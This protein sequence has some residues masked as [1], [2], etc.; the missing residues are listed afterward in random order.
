MPLSSVGCSFLPIVSKY[1]LQFTLSSCFH[2]VTERKRKEGF[3]PLADPAL[4]ERLS[5]QQTSGCRLRWEGLC[6]AGCGTMSGCTWGTAR[7]TTSPE[8]SKG[9]T[10]IKQSSQDTLTVCCPQNTLTER[11]F[12]H[13]PRFNASLPPL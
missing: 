4:S 2:Q 10:N 8:P 9:K 3:L 13:D 11:G 1:T 5:L 7:G 6:G 12:V